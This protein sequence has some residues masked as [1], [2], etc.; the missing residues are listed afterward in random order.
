MTTENKRVC[1]F[2]V[3]VP[4]LM[5]FLSAVG[6]R[7]LLQFRWPVEAFT[8]NGTFV[9]IVLGVNGYD[10]AFQVAGVGTFM[11]TVGTMVGLIFLV[12]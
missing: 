12:R 3:A 1:N 7:V 6:Y 5:E 8:T 10:M 9:W 4:A 11:I 2:I